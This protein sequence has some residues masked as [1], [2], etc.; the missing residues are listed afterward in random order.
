MTLRLFALVVIVLAPVHALTA[1]SR[2]SKMPQA[3]VR[4]VHV[5]SALRIDE[6]V[7]D[8]AE[9]STKSTF[10]IAYQHDVR[11]GTCGLEIVRCSCDG[12][13]GW[14]GPEVRPRP[15]LTGTLF[16]EPAFRRQG[17]AQRLLREAEGRARSWGFG[18]MLLMVK[19]NN[20]PALSLYGNVR[21]NYL[22]SHNPCNGLNP[23]PA[24]L[25]QR[26]WAT[27]QY[28]I[29]LTTGTRFA[30]AGVFI[31]PICIQ[32]TP[33]CLS[34]DAFVQF[35]REV[36]ETF[37]GPLNLFCVLSLSSPRNTLN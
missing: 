29:Q 19:V 37:P 31:L 10:L 9:Q 26:K 25:L 35:H 28:R 12:L 36:Q 23:T 11:V 6:S 14:E 5:A 20:M 13:V 15:I 27:G 1:F 33:C 17:V 8:K 30:C 4:S 18:E 7:F 32:F 21:P 3:S 34:F 22:H 2:S 24:P 16:V